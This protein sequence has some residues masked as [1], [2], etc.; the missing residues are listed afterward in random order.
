MICD[1]SDSERQHKSIS[2]KLQFEVNVREEVNE[3]TARRN[4]E[5]L[6]FKMRNVNVSR[7]TKNG[8]YYY[9]IILLLLYIIIIHYYYSRVLSEKK[10]IYCKTKYFSDL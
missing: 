9:I 4:L 10:P 3:G 5:M 2:Q 8:E 6:R 7:K 1:F